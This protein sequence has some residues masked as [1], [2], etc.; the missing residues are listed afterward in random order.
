MVNADAP[1]PVTVPCDTARLGLLAKLARL[2][3]R[4]QAMR[5]RWLVGVADLQA[6]DDHYAWLALGDADE[7][8]WALRL[9]AQIDAVDCSA[10]AA[11]VNDAIQRCED[12]FTRFSGWLDQED[13]DLGT[14]EA[15]WRSLGDGCPVPQS[16]EPTPDPPPAA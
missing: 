1:Q 12:G 5:S 9:Q 4:W 6:V 8:D 15:S 14:L 11:D 13:Q 3:A 2:R 7:G 10:P 16:P